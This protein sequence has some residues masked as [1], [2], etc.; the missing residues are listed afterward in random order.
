MSLES[1]F[2]LPLAGGPVSVEI[3]ASEDPLVEGRE[4]EVTCTAIGSNPPAL[5]TW[6]E[7]SRY[8]EDECINVSGAAGGRRRRSRRRTSRKVLHFSQTFHCSVYYLRLRVHR[9]FF[10]HYYST[11]LAVGVIR[12]PGNFVFSSV[13]FTIQGYVFPLF[14]LFL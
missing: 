6:Y 3:V 14:F 1:F 2:S 10:S 5:I 12:L 8:V 13:V 4:A 7:E 11:K 9:P